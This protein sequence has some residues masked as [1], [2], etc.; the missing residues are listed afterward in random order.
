[1]D[2]IKAINF[3]MEFPNKDFPKYR[4]L[5]L[6]EC[7]D[8]LF[9]IKNELSM[10]Q[11][12]DPLDLVIQIK[13]NSTLVPIKNNAQDEKFNLEELFRKLNITYQKY[14][15]LNWNRFD[16]VDEIKFKD[17]SKYFN[18]IWYPGADDL[19]IFDQTF[20]WILSISHSSEV[21]L[22]ENI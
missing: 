4:S 15:L 12:I 17:L 11:D 13:N 20:K 6:E 19:D 1:M 14:V 5:S 21:S 8:I 10:A 3:K 7:H 9:R 16:Q 18:Y 2:E 22:I